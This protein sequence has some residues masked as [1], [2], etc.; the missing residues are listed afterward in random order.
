MKRRNGKNFKLKGLHSPSPPR[1]FFND[2]SDFSNV[3]WMF[4][5]AEYRVLHIIRD[6]RD[7]IISAAHYHLTSKEDWLHT[8]RRSFKGMTYQ[9][10]LNTLSDD[11]SRYLFE[12][13]HSAKWIIRALQ[14]WDYNRRNV[15]ECKYESLVV[16]VEM[17]IFDK[18]LLH[19][20]FDASE[21]EKCRAE[22][23]NNS[24]FGKRQGEISTHIRAGTG[25]QWPH[26]FNSNL[27]EA[28]VQRF[29]DVLVTLGYEPDNSWVSK[30]R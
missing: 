23:W 8:P 20:G 2:H 18:I 6:P 1:I 12:M 19:L 30:C 27:A 4:E 7:I 15:L 9:Q 10:K 13:E 25:R 11:Q 28:F 26:V 14:E 5:R 29:G 17:L 16:D 22:I 21:L 24:L 3:P